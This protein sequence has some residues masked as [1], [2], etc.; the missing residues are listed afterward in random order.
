MHI[1]R[2]ED[3]TMVQETITVTV[4]KGFKADV[5]ATVLLDMDKKA[6]WISG[7]IEQPHIL[8]KLAEQLMSFAVA[9]A[10]PRIVGGR[11]VRPS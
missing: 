2:E 5:S 9:Q 4:P 1:I 6:V 8:L 7:P 10:I 3:D 11:I